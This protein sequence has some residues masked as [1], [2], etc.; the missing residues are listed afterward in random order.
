MTPGEPRLVLALNVAAAFGYAFGALCMKA[1]DGFQRPIASVGVFVCFGAA[2]ALQ[3]LAMKHQDVGVGY[4]LVL[5]LEATVAALLGVLVF[6]EPVT[7]ARLGGIA[8][9]VLGVWCLRR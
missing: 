5:G 8:L 2:A 6:R 4:T 7:A 9:V 1:A 3:T